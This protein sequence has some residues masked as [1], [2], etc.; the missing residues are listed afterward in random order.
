MAESGSSSTHDPLDERNLGRRVALGLPVVTIVGAIATGVVVGPATGVL[1]VA[2]GLLLGVI[3]LLWSS[4]RILS[5]DV[6]LPPEI[7]A[8]EA[9]THGVDALASRKNML[10]RALKDLEGERALG[11]LEEED[12][13]PLV[14]G[15]RT[16]LKAVLKKMDEALAPHR[17]R[18]E[19]AARAHLEKVGLLDA[20]GQSAPTADRPAEKEAL[21]KAVV[22]DPAR[23]PC[24]KCG[25]S[26]EA[27][28]KFCKECAAR[29]APATAS[30]TPED[31]AA[32]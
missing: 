25:E 30:V 27:G 24:P 15:Y 18:A 8:L 19:A 2:A 1:V 4:L 21:P 29:I 13:E 9:Q 12:Y 11:K 6:P 17:E 3:A 31:N 22:S 20:R 28:A 16:E 32:R 23:I 7:A 14:A 5:G 26:N 10:L